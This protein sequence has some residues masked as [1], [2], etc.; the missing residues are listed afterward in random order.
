MRRARPP[1]RSCARRCCSSRRCR[2]SC[3]C[4][5][6]CGSRR[7]CASIVNRAKQMHALVVFTVVSTAHRELLRRL[8]RRG[9]RRRGRLDRHADGE[10]VV[11]SRDAAEGRARLVAHDRRRVLPPRRGGRV[12]RAQRRRARAAQPAEGGPRAGGD[13]AHVEDAAVD[14]PGAK[15]PQ[16][17]E[18]AAG[19]RD[20]S[21]DGAVRDRSGAHLRADDQGASRCCRSGRRA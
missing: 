12:H 4:T 21:A 17:G 2:C 1:R 8:V 15:G 7:R 10:A 3:A 18:R 11:V 6:A 14:V 16:G 20:R 13:L 19:A 5:R 9:E